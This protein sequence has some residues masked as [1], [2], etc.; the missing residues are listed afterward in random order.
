MQLPLLC[1]C[2]Y[3][4]GVEWNPSMIPRSIAAML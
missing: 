3:V 1:L 2:I 4:S